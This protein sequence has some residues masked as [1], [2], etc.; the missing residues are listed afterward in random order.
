MPEEP[1]KLDETL[2]AKPFEPPKKW[3][4]KWI[5][6]VL[7]L[8]AAALAAA[9]VCCW[10]HEGGLALLP[11][12]A[13]TE[14]NGLSFTFKAYRPPGSE[15]D[16]V[17]MEMTAKNVSGER[18]V[19]LQN[20]A[21][22]LEATDRRA[23][24]WSAPRTPVPPWTEP[25]VLAPGEVAHVSFFSL[26]Y[27]HVEFADGLGST[28]FLSPGRYKISAVYCVEKDMLPTPD[29]VKRTG[30]RLPEGKVWLGTAKCGPIVV[31][32]S[33]SKWYLNC[34]WLVDALGGLLLAL[35]AWKAVSVSRAWAWILSGVLLAAY[36]AFAVLLAAR[37]W[38]P[39]S[40]LLLPAIGCLT[41][42]ALAAPKAS[43]GLSDGSLPTNRRWLVLLLILS[44][45]LLALGLALWLWKTRRPSDQE[46]S[47]TVG[48]CL[49]IQF[50]VD[51]I[52]P[53]EYERLCAFLTANARACNAA[54]RDEIVDALPW[55]EAESLSG[56]I[57]SLME[58][59]SRGDPQGSFEIAR[60]LR[61]RLD[62][63]LRTY[64]AA[65]DK[66]AFLAALKP[67][68]VERIE[69][70]AAIRDGFKALAEGLL[71]AGCVD[72]RLRWPN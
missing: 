58:E 9:F 48:V 39:W 20:Y 49:A 17:A 22:R 31:P 66:K 6:P 50:S 15:A 12:S 23:S 60:N 11:T 43:G 71:K 5:R 10:L 72:R 27:C 40:M 35:V 56:R 24:Y 63:E 54:I 4:Q 38:M 65:S 69:R 18:L 64:D 2:D 28:L 14:V 29:M 61:L 70:L 1:A 57:L 34:V 8:C 47:R 16:T 55:K 25:R 52:G 37:G 46:V 7:F 36:L 3:R 41:G 53:E 68:E 26:R 13:S 51:H 19:I 62:N 30:F 33:S 42:W 44:A 67:E 59:T 21:C 45:V 32:V